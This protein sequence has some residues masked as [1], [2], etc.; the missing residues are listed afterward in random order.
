M[1]KLNNI[2]D[3][4]DNT[5]IYANKIKKKYISVNEFFPLLDAICVYLASQIFEIIPLDADD[6]G[7]DINECYVV[8]RNIGCN[9]LGSTS[10]KII[11]K[12]WRKL[13]LSA[14]GSHGVIYKDNLGFAYKQV[15]IRENEILA[16]CKHDNIISHNGYYDCKYT[17]YMMMPFIKNN[18]KGFT[19]DA[20]IPIN[21]Q[22]I[23]INQLID[24]IKYLHQNNIV[25]CDIKPDNILI[26]EDCN[27]LYLCDFSLSIIADDVNDIKC[28]YG[29][30]QAYTAPEYNDRK[31][32]LSYKIDIWS[33]GAVIY[34]F[35]TKQNYKINPNCVI[36]DKFIK[37]TLER[38]LVQNPQD[39][40][41]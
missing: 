36:T 26:D 12:N 13:T 33:S 10:N 11:E 38:L 23:I 22:Y 29:L 37:N 21:K 14:K 18:L 27:R 6:L 19:C 5:I 1:E 16:L 17:L 32:K 41:Y 25:H 31:N 4:S 35:H 40:N 34:E 9:I 20:E 39:R 8:Y 3:L 24:S 30:T 7:I 2:F 15:D 28:I